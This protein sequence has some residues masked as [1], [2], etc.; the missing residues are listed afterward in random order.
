MEKEI[1]KEKDMNYHTLCFASDRVSLRA[2]S[3]AASLHPRSV[4]LGIREVRIKKKSSLPQILREF[5]AGGIVYKRR[6]AETQWLVA[7]STPSKLYPESYWRLPKGW[8]DD[9]EG[10]PGPLARGERKASEGDLR[11]AAL[12]EVKEEGGILAKIVEKIGT[13]RI[14]FTKDKVKVLKFVTYYLMEWNRDLP[15][16]PGFE[17]SEVTWLP[18]EK[19]RK[20]LKYPSEKKILDKAKKILD[21]G[22]QQSLV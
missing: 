4:R 10:K 14:F 5:S 3:S 17:T 15:Q 20:K 11:E 8:L 16:G 1:P 22:I 18:F 19:A 9:A 2:S 12:R 6:Q 21:A 7:K 13:E